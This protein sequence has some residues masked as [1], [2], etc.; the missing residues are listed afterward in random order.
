MGRTEREA[1]DLSLRGTVKLRKG[2]EMWEKAPWSRAQKTW[3]LVP[4][5]PFTHPGTQ[6]KSCKPQFFHQQM[7]AIPASQLS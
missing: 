7:E 5:L 1:Q 4:H 6:A 3:V 2:N